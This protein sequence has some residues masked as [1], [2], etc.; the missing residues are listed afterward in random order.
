MHS[1]H[2]H[3]VTFWQSGERD[4]DETTS[5]AEHET[6]KPSMKHT[7]PDTINDFTLLIEASL[8]Q[9]CAHNHETSDQDVGNKR[10]QAAKSDLEIMGNAK[11]CV[12]LWS[13]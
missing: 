10:G 4:V 2:F 9:S 1:V 8:Q 6:H 7:R 5:Q 12:F 3:F 11:V 13:S